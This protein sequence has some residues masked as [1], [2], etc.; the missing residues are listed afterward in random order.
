MTKDDT[1]VMDQFRLDGRAALITGGTKGLGKSMGIG[2]AQAGA[3]VAVC[4][5]HGDEAEAT[6][7]EIASETGQQCIGV[8]ADVTNEDGVKALFAKT[9]DEFGGLHVL[10]NSAGMNIRHPIEEFPLEE[11]QQIMDV[12][13]TGTWLCCR[14]A[15]GIMKKQERGSI[16]NVGSCLSAIGLAERTAYCSSKAAI[17]G[18]TKTL[19]LELAPHGVRC[20]ALCPGPFLTEIN[21]ALLDQPEKVKALLALTALNRWAE[22]PEIRGA[23]LFLASDASSY[24]TGAALYLDGGWTAK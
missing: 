3:K 24:M 7:Q 15:A 10:I 17:L 5:R 9:T 8:Q 23:A 22:L 20:N 14:E 16:V 12:N 19:A 18:M 21:A 13:V 6:A 1:N 4:S 11:F 2:L